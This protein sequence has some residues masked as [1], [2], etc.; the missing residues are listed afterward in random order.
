MV[1]VK[2]K[3]PRL[4]AFLEHGIEHTVLITPREQWD[5]LNV[6]STEMVEI[7]VRMCPISGVEH[8]A[9]NIAIVAHLTCPSAAKVSLYRYDEKDA[10][11]D[12]N[13]DHYSV[14]L[15]LASRQD[16]PVIINRAST[17]FDDNLCKFTQQNVFWIKEKIGEDHWLSYNELPAVVKSVIV[18][19]KSAS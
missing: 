8:K 18:I 14:E 1:H 3:A 12:W 7:D 5:L 16:L 2:V 6:G 4:Q 10:P 9:A 19:E 13:V 11:R 17:S 15:D